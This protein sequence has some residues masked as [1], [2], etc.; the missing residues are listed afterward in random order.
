MTE[1][2]RI[3]NE[4][5]SPNVKAVTEEAEGEGAVDEEAEEAEGEAAVGTAGVSL[6]Q[7][8]RDQGR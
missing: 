4:R 3:K 8:E 5:P 2:G 1:V 6:A 7:V